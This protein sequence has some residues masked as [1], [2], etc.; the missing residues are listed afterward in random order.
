MY[1]I[2]TNIHAAYLL[3]NFEYDEL[4]KQYLKLYENITLGDRVVP[5]FI[6][7]EFETFIMRVV[8]PRYQLNSEDKN[9]LK[10]LSLEYIDRLTRQCTIIVPDVKTVQKAR[11]IYLKYAYSNYISFTD[12]LLLATAQQNNFMLFSKDA[13]LNAIAQ[14]L[15]IPLLKP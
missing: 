14:Q 11:D 4:T 13:R 9:K 7:G 2:D 10:Q 8:P 12:S 1:L 6:L 3:Q 5:D 15:D